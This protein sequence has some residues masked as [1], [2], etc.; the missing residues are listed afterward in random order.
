M[1][2]FTPESGERVPGKINYPREQGLF[3]QPIFLSRTL[4]V[5]TEENI[6][7]IGFGQQKHEGRLCEAGPRPC[8]LPERLWVLGV[9]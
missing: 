7:G 8:L 1:L 4:L 5:I 3:Y 6:E 9:F 2:L